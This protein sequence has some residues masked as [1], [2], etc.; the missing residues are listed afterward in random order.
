MIYQQVQVFADLSFTYILCFCEG[1]NDVWQVYLYSNHS[2]P[3]YYLLW[4]QQLLLIALMHQETIFTA[5]KITAIKIHQ[6]NKI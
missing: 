6:R 5:M 4:R 3:S 1:G 2:V